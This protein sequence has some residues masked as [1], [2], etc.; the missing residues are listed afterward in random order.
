MAEPNPV[1]HEH[2]HAP[3]APYSYWEPP[4]NPTP[5]Q[6]EVHHDRARD[7]IN[8]PHLRGGTLPTPPSE[9]STDPRD[10]FDRFVIK[11]VEKIRNMNTALKD[12]KLTLDAMEQAPT[13]MEVLPGPKELAAY[14]QARAEYLQYL[15]DHE[16][17]K[18]SDITVRPVLSTE[19]FVI[20]IEIIGEP[21]GAGHK[22]HSSSYTSTHP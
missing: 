19:G 8:N 4:Q 1:E 14:K 3:Q 12:Y 15:L 22:Q 20:D 7:R 6:T 10:L 13:Q 11:L 21:L 18:V 2:E 17:H 16:T 5:Y 9:N